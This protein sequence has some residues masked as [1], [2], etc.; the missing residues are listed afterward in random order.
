MARRSNRETGKECTWEQIPLP[1]LAATPPRSLSREEINILVAA[2]EIT[3]IEEI[4]D[5]RATGPYYH[6]GE[7]GR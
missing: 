5:C 7:G 6:W 1:L 2:G 3:P 4:R